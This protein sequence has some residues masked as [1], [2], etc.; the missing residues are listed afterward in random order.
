MEKAT[1]KQES[2]VDPAL[3]PP[4]LRAVRRVVI[5]TVITL[6]WAAAGI[7]LYAYE[8]SGWGAVVI[9]VGL[10]LLLIGGTRVSRTAAGPIMGLV[11]Y[12]FYML[13]AFLAGKNLV[14][15]VVLDS[16]GITQ[17]VVVV[18]AE[19]HTSSA[20]SAGTETNRVYQVRTTNGS[21]V[22]GTLLSKRLKSGGFEHGQHDVGDTVRVTFDP[23]G[24]VDAAWPGETNVVRDGILLGGVPLSIIVDFGVCGML[25]YR[26]GWKG[27]VRKNSVRIT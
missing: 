20:G 12:M 18:S 27:A 3:Q 4:A 1:Q 13:S 21:D 16:R 14:Q 7:Y 2:Y 10:L 9:S 17:D 8:R 5:P 19:K 11:V 15:D 22:R 23:E 6:V 26:E 25:W 24:H